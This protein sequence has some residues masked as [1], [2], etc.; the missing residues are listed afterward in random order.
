MESCL[1]FWWGFLIP[2]SDAAKTF[3]TA[4]NWSSFSFKA[5][6]RGSCTA[7]L[8]GF[9]SCLYQYFLELG[10]KSKPLGAQCFKNTTV[11][12]SDSWRFASTFVCEG[13]LFFILGWT[14][15]SALWTVGD[16]VFPD[17]C[18][19]TANII[20]SAWHV[21]SVHYGHSSLSKWL[22]RNG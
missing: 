11:L 7:S 19:T 17:P 18:P 4:G 1:P 13:W 5:T 16:S 22:P 3:S 2:S 15:H 20:L 14:G 9:G 8:G 12:S 21:A 10:I 6:K